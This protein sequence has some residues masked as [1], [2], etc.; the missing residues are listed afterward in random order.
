MLAGKVLPTVNCRDLVW[1]LAWGLRRRNQ[2]A[3]KNRLLRIYEHSRTYILG[4]PSVRHPHRQ[5]V[6]RGTSQCDLVPES[7]TYQNRILAE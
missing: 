4:P 1:Q 7:S 5:Y 6:V 2:V 3:S